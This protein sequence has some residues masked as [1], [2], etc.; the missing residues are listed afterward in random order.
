MVGRRRIWK[1]SS[2]KY[3]IIETLKKKKTMMDDKLFES[4]QKTHPYLGYDDLIV[5]LFEL[6]TMG[7][8]NVRKIS[9]A[10]MIISIAE[11]GYAGVEED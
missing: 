6:E 5:V 3:D 10:R 8:I 1:T 7:Y 9:Q 2:L 11:E 4:L